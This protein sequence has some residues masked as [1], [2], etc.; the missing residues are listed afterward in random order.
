[1]TNDIANRYIAAARIQKAS[2]GASDIPIA[3]R[4]QMYARMQQ[5]TAPTGSTVTQAPMATGSIAGSYQQAAVQQNRAASS[6]S[7]KTT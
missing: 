1:M 4:Y 2:N 3:D 7:S 6:G 5:S